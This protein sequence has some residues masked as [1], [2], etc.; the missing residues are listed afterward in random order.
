MDG[1]RKGIRPTG[2]HRTRGL[3]MIVTYSAHAQS[4]LTDTSWW[5]STFK[6]GLIIAIILGFFIG[7]GIMGK[8][9]GA[10]IVVVVWCLIY[11]PLFFIGGIIGTAA[12]SYADNQSE[13][14]AIPTHSDASFVSSFESPYCLSPLRYTIAPM[15]RPKKDPAQCSLLDE[16][17]VQEGTPHVPAGYAG[18]SATRSRRDAN[19]STD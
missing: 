17:L 14:T 4:T 15:A 1:L 8:M 10:I 6:I 7:Q 19:A 9:G 13:R 11:W 3:K 5:D 2:A 18:T 12:E 16:L